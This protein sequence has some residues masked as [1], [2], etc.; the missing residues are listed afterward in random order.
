MPHRW[1]K[2]LLAASAIT[3]A[4]AVTFGAKDPASLQGDNPPAGAIRVD[5][6]DVGDVPVRRP[7]ADPARG[8]AAGQQTP[9]TPTFRS[10]VELIPVNV[11]VLGRDGRPV[12][13]LKKENFTILEDG[14]PQELRHFSLESIVAE[15]SKASAN[16]AVGRRIVPALELV[17]QE[18]RVFL[19]VLSTWRGNDIQGPNKG[20]DALLE[21]VNKRLLPQDVVAAMAYNRAT[22]FTTNHAAIVDVIERYRAR[23]DKIGAALEAFF[24]GLRAVYGSGR[25]PASTQREID[26]VFDVPGASMRQLPAIDARPIRSSATPPIPNPDADAALEDYAKAEAGFDQRVASS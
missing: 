26:E 5:R 21:F 7:G 8:Q 23:S 1:L 11:S 20:L 3:L 12:V 10:A 9:Q 24:S 4:A 22:V 18:R 19:I 2:G 13:D 15:T 16:E 14:V 6:L 25:I 17:P